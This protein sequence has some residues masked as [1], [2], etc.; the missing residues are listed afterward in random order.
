MFPYCTGWRQRI[1]AAVTPCCN[2]VLMQ[3]SC[4]QAAL[5]R[6]CEL[7]DRVRETAINW[8]EKQSSDYS[9]CSLLHE[10]LQKLLQIC[11]DNC[12]VPENTLLHAVIAWRAECLQFPKQLAH[13]LRTVLKPGVPAQQWQDEA[14][15]S[16]GEG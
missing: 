8:I 15:V 5:P 9:S 10:F 12:G 16:T 14:A 7:V 4:L 3:L 2:A 6:P 13:R 1:F 11:K